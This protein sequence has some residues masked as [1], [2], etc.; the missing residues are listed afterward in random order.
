MLSKSSLGRG[1]IVGL[2]SIGQRHLKNIRHMY[3]DIELIVHRHQE[4]KDSNIQGIKHITN[5]LDEALDLEPDFAII[6]NPSPSSFHNPFWA[7]GF[8]R[9]CNWI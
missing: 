9:S 4:N 1:L 6:C 2:G 3:G 8:G 5:D 7:F